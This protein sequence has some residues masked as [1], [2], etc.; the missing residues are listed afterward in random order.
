MLEKAAIV[1]SNVIKSIA[2]ARRPGLSA[3]ITADVPPVS[4]VRLSLTSRP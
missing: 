2:A 4:I 1:N 3:P